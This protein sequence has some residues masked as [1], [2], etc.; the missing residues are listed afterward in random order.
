MLFTRSSISAPNSQ[1]MRRSMPMSFS[2]RYSRAV[3]VLF[4]CWTVTQLRAQSASPPSTT[5]IG[6]IIGG[7]EALGAYASRLANGAG[8]GLI[9]QQSLPARR[10]ALRGTLSTQWHTVSGCNI[11]GSDCVDQHRTTSIRSVDLALVGRIL[12]TEAHWS[13]YV[14]LGG[15]AHSYDSHFP[16]DLLESHARRAGTLFGVGF[17]VDRDRAT[18]FGEWRRLAAPPG[19]FAQFNIGGRLTLGSRR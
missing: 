9:V 8:L 1:H 11:V 2:L 12:P 6:L 4:S 15:V 3:L 5:S 18:Y 13:P 19:S 7:G 17:D 14:M 16:D 10:F